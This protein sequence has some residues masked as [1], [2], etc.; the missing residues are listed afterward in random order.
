MV[1]Q[2]EHA[3]QV[4]APPRAPQATKQVA[5]AASHA[6]LAAETADS[7]TYQAAAHPALQIAVASGPDSAVLVN[8]V[9]TRRNWTAA[10]IFLNCFF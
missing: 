2:S 10:F 5:S 1:T 7:Q 6:L 4:G 8:R 3:Q 9:N